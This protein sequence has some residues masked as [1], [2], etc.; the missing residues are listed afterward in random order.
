MVEYLMKISD[1]IGNLEI[2]AF[3]VYHCSSFRGIW[4][5]E[6]GNN[7]VFRNNSERLMVIII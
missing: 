7:Y 4:L 6:H 2:T 5:L 1:R 3:L